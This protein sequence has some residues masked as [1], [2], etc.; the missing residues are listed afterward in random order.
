MQILNYIWFHPNCKDKRVQSI[1]KFIGWQLYKRLINKAIDIQLIPG[2]KI[3]CHPKGYAA[4]AVLYCGLYDYDEMNFLLRYLRPE[5]SFL[6]IGAN[7]G[8]YTLLAASKIKTGIVYSFEALPKNHQR[9]EENLELNQFHHVKAYSLAISNS[10]GDISLELAEGDSMPFITS[11]A[12]EKSITVATNSLDCLLR[13][14][15]IEN[16]TLAKIDIEGA[17][18]LAFKGA[19]LLL[20]QQRPYV[21]IMELNGTVG[22]F[23]HTQQDVV[24]FLRDYG[25]G[26]YYYLSDANQLASIETGQQQGNN[27]LA[28]ASNRLD[29]VKNRLNITLPILT[30]I[31]K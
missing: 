3:R 29:L 4:A 25:Y 12:S 11:Q 22:H 1:L 19:T 13:H 2:V 27:V 24:D 18:L 20:Q 16:L 23:G 17:E 10:Q 6:D 14:E 31:S 21:W 9:L 5:D 26:L 8:V 7:V 28:I 15:P 30:S